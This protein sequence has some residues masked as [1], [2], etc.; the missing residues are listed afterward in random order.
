MPLAAQA[1]LGRRDR[2]YLLSRLLRRPDA[3]RDWLYARCREVEAVPDDYL[4]LWAREQA[5]HGE[6]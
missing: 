6:G 2:F 3:D 4:D 1:A 5:P